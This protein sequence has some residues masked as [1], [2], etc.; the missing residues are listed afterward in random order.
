[1]T[2][3]T[4]TLQAESAN[5]YGVTYRSTYVY[6]TTKSHGPTRLV[7][8]SN[9]DRPN[10]DLGKQLGDTLRNGNKVTAYSERYTRGQYV[11]PHNEPTDSPVSYLLT[12]ESTA[13]CA[14]TRFNTGQPGS[15]QV[16][17]DGTLADGDTAELTYP[18]GT[19]ELVTLHLPAHHNG[20]GS[21]AR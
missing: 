17:G 6:Q 8:W 1:M 12:P 10:P 5:D 16:Y 9:T 4:I 7:V 18:D 20:H 19:T 21:A 3:H 15:G 11:D 13:I 14:D 2:Q